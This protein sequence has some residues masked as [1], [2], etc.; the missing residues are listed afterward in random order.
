MN[1]L[2]LVLALATV[3][4]A[5]P[6]YEQYNYEPAVNTAI[7]SEG[8]WVASEEAWPEEIQ[9][10]NRDGKGIVDSLPSLPSP[11]GLLAKLGNWWTW[12]R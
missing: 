6:N 4:L 7:I 3:S 11:S 9:E 1:S 5:L 8:P 12:D 10:D 2:I